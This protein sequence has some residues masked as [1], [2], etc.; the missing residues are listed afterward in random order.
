VNASAT[1][2]LL[3]GL[4]ATICPPSAQSIP[5]RSVRLVPASQILAAA[6]VL[7]GGCSA[8]TP[9]RYVAPTSE[10]IVSTTEERG[11]PPAHLIFVENRSSVPVKVF[12]VTLSSCQNVKLRCSTRPVSIWIQPGHRQL[13]IRVEPGTLQRGFSYRFGFSWNTDSPSARGAPAPSGD[14]RRID[15]LQLVDSIM[16]R[17][18]EGPRELTRDDF[19]ALAGRA[20]TLR[21]HPES[22]VLA[23]GERASIDRVQL[24]L[25]DS[26]GVVLGRTRWVRWRV[27]DS[28]AVQFLPP[29]DIVARAPGRATVRVR[30]ADEAE[31]I[32]KRSIPEIE[33]PVVVAYAVD[34]H[35]P[36]FTGLARDADTR[37]PLACARVA[38][39]DSAQN[40][41][42]TDRTGKSGTFV[43]HTPRPG[44]YRVRVETF[45]WAPAYGPPQAA[46]ADEMKQHEYLVRFVE[47]LLT[48]RRG[49]AFDAFQPAYPAAVST[50]PVGEERA[51]ATTPVVPGVT[52]GGSESTPIL[53]IIGS[54]PA[55]TTWIQFVVDSTGRVDPASLILPP[56]TSTPAAASVRSVLPRVRFSPAREAGKPTCEL[57]RMQVNFSPR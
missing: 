18:R 30:L 23:P 9:R 57:V 12:R 16:H 53:G 25:A 36:V 34:P 26:R 39:E 27:V 35:A 51:A 1:R 40:V 19:A 14:E 3:P 47:Q 2:Y 45:G 42:A 29:E 54:A 5:P 31:A 24:F 15:V 7:L 37:A 49:M 50:A 33:Y 21:V 52:L 44:T 13:V 11:D 8:P 43:L 4:V 10:T 56:T 55:G 38:L 32:L 22:L 6:V 41:V 17:A 28:N 46:G 20:T 48:P